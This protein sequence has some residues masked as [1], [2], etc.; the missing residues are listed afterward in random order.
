MAKAP[1]KDCEKRELGCH[2]RCEEY[3]E[4]KKQNEKAKSEYPEIYK[5][6]SSQR[7]RKRYKS[8]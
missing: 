2:G 1:C 7:V 5:Y 8:I 4:Y 3:A 6:R